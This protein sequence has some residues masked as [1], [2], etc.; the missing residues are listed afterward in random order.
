MHCCNGAK[1]SRILFIVQTKIWMF[2]NHCDR[3]RKRQ[4]RHGEWRYDMY[5][6]DVACITQWGLH[7]W[8]SLHRGNMVEIA[9]CRGDRHPCPTHCAEGWGLS[10]LKYGW[11]SCLKNTNIT[12]GPESRQDSMAWY[13]QRGTNIKVEQAFKDH[14]MAKLKGLGDLFLIQIALPEVE[15]T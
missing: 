6:V 15:H 12:L 5:I 9:G 13:G 1:E 11:M 3:L 4:E 10:G 2:H 7:Y 8:I 14:L